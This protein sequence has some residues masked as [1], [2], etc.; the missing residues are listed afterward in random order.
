[1]DHQQKPLQAEVCKGFCLSHEEGVCTVTV[2]KA[3]KADINSIMDLLHQVLEVHHAGRPDIFKSGV[4]KYTEDELTEIIASPKTPVL[5]AV[6]E[7]ENVCGHAF[8]VL[9][10]SGENAVLVDNKT[11]YIDDICV[12][13]SHRG[14]GI[15][16][17]L[18]TAAQRLAEEKGC[19]NVTLNVW[20]ANEGAVEFYKAMGFNP[21]RI[22]MEKLL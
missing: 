6:D 13:E 17:L 10:K 8:C 9:K 2:R 16:K 15:G 20:C 7:N 4:T 22:T 5:V 3:A 19:H 1:M 11:M 14:Q 21:Q 12:H 18:C